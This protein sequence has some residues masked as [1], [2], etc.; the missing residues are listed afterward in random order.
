MREGG[1]YRLVLPY[2]LGYGENGNRGIQPYE[3]LSF[4]IE[5]IKSGAPGT[6]VQAQQMAPQQQISPEQLKQ[7]QEELQ[8]QQE[9]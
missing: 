6:L 7:L 4:E 5:V 2:D 3:T 8:K 1:R 9:Q